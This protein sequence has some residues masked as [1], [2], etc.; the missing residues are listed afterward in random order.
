[1]IDSNVFFA[2]YCKNKDEVVVLPLMGD[3]ESLLTEATLYRK[4][5]FTKYGINIKT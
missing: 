2:C 4:K 1:M 3:E 5:R